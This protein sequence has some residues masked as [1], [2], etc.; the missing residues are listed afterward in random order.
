MSQIS[1]IKCPHCGKWSTGTGKTDEKCPHCHEYLN[2]V[3]VQYLEENRVKTETNKKNNFLVINEN[4]D[5]IIQM[6]KQFIN[7]LAWTTFYGISVIYIVIALMVIVYG[8][9]MI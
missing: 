4:D 8:L 9:F 7:W 6:F 5:P 1:E 3:R 2:P